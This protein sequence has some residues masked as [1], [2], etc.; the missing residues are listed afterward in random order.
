MK[1]LVTIEEKGKKTFNYL[2]GQVAS[3]KNE[4]SDSNKH[5]SFSWHFNDAI[6]QERL[7]SVDIM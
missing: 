4:L 1:A 6:Y 5:F 3:N 2:E 7:C